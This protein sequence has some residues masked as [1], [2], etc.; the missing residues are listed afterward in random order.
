MKNVTSPATSLVA[1]LVLMLVVRFPA[2]GTQDY[3]AAVKAEVQEFKTGKFDLSDRSPWVP[4]ASASGGTGAAD[5][6]FKE[7]AALLR[8]KYPGTFI[9]FAKLSDEQQRRIHQEYV[10]TGDFSRIR[11]NI[12]NTLKGR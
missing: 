6:R 3:L 8:K 10:R 11:T 7:F 4:P 9:Q 2:A 5:E 1:I 12:L